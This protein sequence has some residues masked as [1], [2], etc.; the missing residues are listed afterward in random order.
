MAV[1]QIRSQRGTDIRL[2]GQSS[3]GARL[4]RYTLE[5]VTYFLTYS[6]GFLLHDGFLEFSSF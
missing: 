2:T 4:L 6:S 5:F 1:L 3:H